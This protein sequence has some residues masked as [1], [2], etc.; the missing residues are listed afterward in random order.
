MRGA[1]PVNDELEVGFN[2][3][4]ETGWYYASVASQCVMAALVAA[5]L[6]GLF[7]RGPFSHRSVASDA[8]GLSM[9]FE[10]VARY[11]T[12]TQV[13]LHLHP[14][15]DQRT[16]EVTIS[17]G[18]VEPL[19]LQRVLP[20]PTTERPGRHG[21]LILSVAI[22]PGEREA[23]VRLMEQPAVIGRIPIECSL[24]DGDTVRATQFVMP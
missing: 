5:A 8:G 15:P 10:P 21:G 18:T 16:V 12:S 7:G 4:F 11:A 14:S 17:P 24:A 19:G 3:R 2:A 1:D 13:T 23:L 20:Q 22:P 6:L 9:D